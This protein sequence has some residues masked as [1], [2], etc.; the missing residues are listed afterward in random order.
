ME[1]L[2]I[3]FLHMDLLEEEFRHPSAESPRLIPQT[4][5]EIRTALARLEALV[6]LSRPRAR[7]RRRAERPGLGGGR[8]GSGRRRCTARRRDKGWT[9]SS[10]DSRRRGSW[11]F[12]P[13]PCGRRCSTWCRMPSRPCRRGTLTLACVRTATAVQ[14]RVSDTGTGMPAEHARADF[15]AAHTTKPGDRHG[16]V[17]RA[18]DPERPRGRV[19]VESVEGRAAPSPSC[20]PCRESAARTEEARSSHRLARRDVRTCSGRPAV[21]NGRG[22]PVMA[23]HRGPCA[24]GPFSGAP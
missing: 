3:L 6:G 21:L 11:R 4:F 17:S 13:T 5:H 12:T 1:P 16:P 10:R 18:G 24:P 15:R 9:S 7:G 2:S 20:S 19:T 23:W 22:T 8:A 14:L